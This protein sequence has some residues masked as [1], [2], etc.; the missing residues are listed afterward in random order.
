MMQIVM[1]GNVFW[2]SLHLAVLCN[3]L[4]RKS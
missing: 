2:K 1:L 3:Q 4:L